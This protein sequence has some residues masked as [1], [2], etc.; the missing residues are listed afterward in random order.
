MRANLIQ[1]FVLPLES[2]HS[3]MDEKGIQR[4]WYMRAAMVGFMGKSL[5][6]IGNGSTFLT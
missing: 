2:L 1:V 5:Q 3:S 6:T 4:K